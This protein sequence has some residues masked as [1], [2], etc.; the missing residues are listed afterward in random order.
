MTIGTGIGAGF[1]TGD[2]IVRGAHGAAGEL[3]HIPVDPTGL[4]CGPGCPSFGCLE[5]VV[6]GPALEREAE[7]VAVARPDSALGKA[8]AQGPL[9]GPRIVELAHDGDLAAVDVLSIVGNW[10]GIGLVAVANMLD[11]EVI[12]IGGGLAAAGELLIEPATAVLRERAMPP[13]SGASVVAAKFGADAGLL[14]A[15]L[16]ARG[17]LASA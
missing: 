10:L 15:S 11:P 8:A 3:G 4:K 14:G 16:I 13:A 5:T 6:S 17:G 12:V 9:S 2:R 7:R 1:V